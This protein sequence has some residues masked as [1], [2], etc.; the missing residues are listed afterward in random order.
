MKK[1]EKHKINKYLNDN[2]KRKLRNIQITKK[3]ILTLPAFTK[4]LKE[5]VSDLNTLVKLD[6]ISM[7][8]A[9]VLTYLLFSCK[10]LVV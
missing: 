4:F 9:C 6:W 2:Y 5:N 1:N 10:T 7:Y 3:K 8:N